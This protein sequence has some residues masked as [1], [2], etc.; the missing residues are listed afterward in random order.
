MIIDRKNAHVW[1]CTTGASVG[2][3]FNFI[4][5]DHLPSDLQLFLKNDNVIIIKD[6]W[7]SMAHLVA[8]TKFFS[9]VSEAKK[10]GWNIPIPTGYSYHVL[11]NPKK[12][13]FIT[14]FIFVPV[15]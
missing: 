1:A 12:V 10:N 3:V 8:E 13:N 5:K 4:S 15:P 14:M 7:T 6:E 11:G 9:S 2:K